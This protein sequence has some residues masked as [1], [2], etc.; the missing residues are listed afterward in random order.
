MPT[1]TEESAKGR[2][3]FTGQRGGRY[4]V[5]DFGARVYITKSEPKVRRAYHPPRGSYARFLENQID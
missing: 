5:N 4:F 1:A 2:K 3:I